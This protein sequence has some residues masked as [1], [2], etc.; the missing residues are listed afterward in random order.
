MTDLPHRDRLLQTSSSTRMGDDDLVDDNVATGTPRRPEPE[1]RERSNCFGSTG[2]GEEL[3]GI[4][5]AA[6]RVLSSLGELD[7]GSHDEVLHR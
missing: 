7:P 1:S 3:P 2:C 4:G 5:H 6:Q